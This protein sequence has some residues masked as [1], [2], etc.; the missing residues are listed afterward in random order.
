MQEENRTGKFNGC[1]TGSGTCSRRVELL[2]QSCFG[3]AWQSCHASSSPG[4]TAWQSACRPEL[5]PRLATA[6]SCLAGQRRR[7]G[8]LFRRPGHLPHPGARAAALRLPGRAVRSGSLRLNW[9][10]YRPTGG[11]GP[12]MAQC[13]GVSRAAGQGWQGQHLVPVYCGPSLHVQVRPGRCGSRRHRR[14]VCAGE[15]SACSC[16]RRCNSQSQ[17]GVAHPAAG[18]WAHGSC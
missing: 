14:R 18:S 12:V 7:L 16:G 13:W 15:S 9:F 2:W 6:S 1:W 4:T 3:K 17:P 10:G 5:L 8:H 11:E